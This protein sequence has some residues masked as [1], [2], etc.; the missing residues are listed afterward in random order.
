MAAMERGIKT[1]NLGQ[2]RTARKERTN[3]RK[4]VGLMQWCQRHIALQT[5]EHA[6]IKQNR[7]IV[8]WPAMNNAM[9]YGDNVEALILAQPTCCLVDCGRD[10]RY[11]MTRIFFVDEN[12]LVIRLGTQPRPC[13]NAV[14]LTLDQPDQAC[15][16]VYSEHLKLYARRAGVDHQNGVHGTS[17]GRQCHRAAARISIEHCSPARCH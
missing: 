15:G 8:F 3:W 11:V 7:P 17:R 16:A 9:A 4:V 13:A 14:H 1:G 6:P 10:V 12:G 5:L 2:L